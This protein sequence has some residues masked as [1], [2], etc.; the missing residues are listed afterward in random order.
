M[1]F[2]EVVSFILF[3]LV[4]SQ[5]TLDDELNVIQDRLKVL[6][7]KSCVSPVV[8][9]T[10]E[11]YMQEGERLFGKDVKEWVYK[12][13][14][15]ETNQT[16]NDLMREGVNKEK[17]LDYLGFSCIGRFKEKTE[18]AF[19]GNK[20]KMKGKGCDYT[21]GGLIALP[22]VIVHSDGKKHKRF[23]FGEKDGVQNNRETQL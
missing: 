2:K 8:Y 12:C 5:C 18:S 19:N 7:D 3:C 20:K 9:P 16:A 22:G 6:E 13:P 15:C 21:L 4:V 11:S 17:V 10:Y 1:S 23:A 14:M